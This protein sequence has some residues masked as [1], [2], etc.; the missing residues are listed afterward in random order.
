MVQKRRS[1]HATGPTGQNMNFRGSSINEGRGDAKGTR[2]TTAPT[3]IRE[4]LTM[5]VLY[6]CKKAIFYDTNLKVALY[7]GSLFLVS[8][9]GDFMPYPRTYFARSDNLFNQYFVKIGWF[10]TM[11][12]TIPY[13]L[14]TSYVVCCGDAKRVVK[15][16]IIRIGIATACWYVWTTLFNVIESSFGRCTDKRF[17]TKSSCLKAGFLWNGFDISGHAFILIYSSLVLIEEART[18]VNWE[19]IKEH[20]RNEEHNRAT[21]D[22]TNARNPLSNLKDDEFARLNFLYTRY[23]PLI[24]LLFVAMTVLQILWDVMLVATMLY[25]HKMIEKV[26]SGIIAILMWFFTYRF[27]YA[28]AVLPDPVGKGLFIYQREKARP[29]PIPMRRNPSVVINPATGKPMPRFM[30]MPLYTGRQDASMSNGPNPEP[31]PSR[32]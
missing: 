8:L 21:A 14:L 23:T 15:H 17:V 13:S 12:L 7:L 25:F 30:G 28:S 4:V 10:W 29:E 5:M 16:H 1:I 2:P 18:I 31:G 27:W 26:I 32:F 24:R 20:L 6:I 3:S 19:S 11:I 9:I 22:S